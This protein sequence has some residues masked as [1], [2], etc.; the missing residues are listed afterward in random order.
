MPLQQVSYNKIY[1]N[2]IFPF[3]ITRLILSQK[4]FKSFADE[5]EYGLIVFTL[6]SNSQVSSMPVHIQ[7]IFLRVFARLPQ[8]IIWKWEMDSLSQLPNN[9][10]MVDWLPQQDLL[11]NFYCFVKR[12]WNIELNHFQPF[13]KGHKN[14]R[15]FI[16]HGGLMGIQEVAYII[17][18][19]YVFKITI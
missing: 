8:R 10:K 6:G 11:G 3:L 15:L 5:A 18:Q 9:V 14:T 17:V 4:D 2:F 1:C 7:E 16:A 19:K 12:D 13:A